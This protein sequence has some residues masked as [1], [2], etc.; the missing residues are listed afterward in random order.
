MSSKRKRPHPLVLNSV[1]TTLAD[2]SNDFL[3]SVVIIQL[4][5]VNKSI[6]AIAFIVRSALRSSKKLTSL[7]VAT[8]SGNFKMSLSLSNNCHDSYS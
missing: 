6:D 3:W 1:N 2:I 4:N 7:N 8:L 5:I